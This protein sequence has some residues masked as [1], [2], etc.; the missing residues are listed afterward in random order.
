MKESIFG[1]IVN[2]SKN[3]LAIKL[4]GA[5]K[6]EYV[7][8]F[9]VGFITFGCTA[10]QDQPG[11]LTALEKKVAG[12]IRGTISNCPM[13]SQ[14]IVLYGL[15]HPDFWKQKQEKYNIMKARANKVKDVLNTGKFND[16]FVYYPF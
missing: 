7:W 8:G 2:R 15:T 5:T 14:T 13:V 3:L 16:E 1:H 6:E 10:N 9:R 11:L 12:I 4:D